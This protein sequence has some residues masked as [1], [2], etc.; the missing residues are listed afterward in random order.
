MSWKFGAE[1]ERP[2]LYHLR[3]TSYYGIFPLLSS[4]NSGFTYSAVTWHCSSVSLNLLSTCI[5]I[6]SPLPVQWWWFSKIEYCLWGLWE[7]AHIGYT[8]KSHLDKGHDVDKDLEK[9]HFSI[10]MSPLFLPSWWA[11]EHYHTFAF[12]SAH[13]KVSCLTPHVCATGQRPTGIHN[14]TQQQNRSKLIWKSSFTLYK[15]SDLC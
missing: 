8:P 6:L 15:L 10:S 2:A 7:G 14:W 3:G 13:H 12:L 1:K 9:S 5:F 4:H 11:R